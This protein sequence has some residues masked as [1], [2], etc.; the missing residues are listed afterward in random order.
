MQGKGKRI[1]LVVLTLALCF[2]A[3][4]VA[5]RVFRGIRE[6]PAGGTEVET[7]KEPEIEIIIPEPVGEPVA[8]EPSGL[9]A[10]S[11]GIMNFSVE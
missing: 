11:I 2:V 9:T 7:V 5:F 1:L 10:Y 3:L 8:D 6:K 4:G